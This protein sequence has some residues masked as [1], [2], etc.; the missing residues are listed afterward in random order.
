LIEHSDAVALV[1]VNVGSLPFLALVEG[2]TGPD[3]AIPAGL[4]KDLNRNIVG[5]VEIIARREAQGTWS[6]NRALDPPD[7]TVAVG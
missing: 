5:E 1:H 7:E 6:Y 3:Y 2:Q 4:I